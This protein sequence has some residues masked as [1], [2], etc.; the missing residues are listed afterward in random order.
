MYEIIYR[1]YAIMYG[2]YL[3]IYGPSDD[4]IWIIY[5]PSASQTSIDECFESIDFY[6]RVQRSC[7]ITEHVKLLH[8]D[9]IGSGSNDTLLRRKI[10]RDKAAKRKLGFKNIYHGSTSTSLAYKT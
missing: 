1:P 4:H 10:S 6:K 7:H 5:D 3:S 2:P 9:L 8:L